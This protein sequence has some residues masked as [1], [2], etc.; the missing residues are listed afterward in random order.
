MESQNCWGISNLNEDFYI[1]NIKALLK[2]HITFFSFASIALEIKS[3]QL[4]ESKAYLLSCVFSGIYNYISD[5][6]CINKSIRLL[7]NFFLFIWTG[8]FF[9]LLN[10]CWRLLPLNTLLGLW[11]T[12]ISWFSSYT[13]GNSFPVSVCCVYLTCST[14]KLRIPQNCIFGLFSLCILSLDDIHSHSFNYCA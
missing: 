8:I 3:A 1:W 10:Y 12:T 11:N 9:F 13:L 2:V 7:F 5:F 6:L 14:N 4:K